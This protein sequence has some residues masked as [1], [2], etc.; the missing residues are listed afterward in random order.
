MAIN[1]SQHP[2]TLE[3]MAE[4]C[5]LES[6]RILQEDQEQGRIGGTRGEVLAAVAAKIEKEIEDAHQGILNDEHQDRIRKAGL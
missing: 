3:E 6:Q 2:I 4:V 5:R 1:R